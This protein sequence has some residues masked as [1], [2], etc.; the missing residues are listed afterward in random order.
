MNDNLFFKPTPLYK[1][2]VI[3]DLIEKNSKITQRIMSQ[4]LGVAVSMVNGYLD[5][6]ESKGFVKRKRYS[7]KTV[8]YFVTK[9][10]TE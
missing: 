2:F 3:L 4:E 8:E 7:T 10:G 5:D 9:D 6:Y 1:E